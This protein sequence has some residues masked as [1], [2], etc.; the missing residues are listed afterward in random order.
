MDWTMNR[1]TGLQLASGAGGFALM[2][3]LLLVGAR[4]HAQAPQSFAFKPG[5]WSLTR[6]MRGGPDASAHGKTE[7]VCFDAATLASEPA[8]PMRIRPPKTD[9][10]APQCVIADLTVTGGTASYSTLCKGPMGRIRGLWTGTHAADRFA[11]SGR[12][13]AMFMTLTA[14]YSGRWL[15]ACKP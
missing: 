4:A 7:E 2:A 6:T 1:Q 15:G 3:V 12:M 10:K 8:A 9:K 14:Q 13:K 5:L 11:M